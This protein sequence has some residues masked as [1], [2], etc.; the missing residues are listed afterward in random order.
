VGST[1][2]VY[3]LVY[4]DIFFNNNRANHVTEGVDI[5]FY[6]VL[7]IEDPYTFY[8]RSANVY[9]KVGYGAAVAGIPLPI[10]MDQ[11][12]VVYELPLNYGNTSSS[13][14]AYDIA[15]PNLAYYGYRQVRTNV[16]DGWG[17][18]NTPAGSFNALR[19]KTVIAGRD[20]IR[21]DTLSVAFAI[22]RPLYTEYKWLTPGRK[23]PVLQIN[24][25][26]ILNT[27]VITEV[28]FYDVERTLAVV[29]PLSAT[30][31]PGAQVQVPYTR[32][33]VFNAGGLLVP[34]NVFRVQLSDASGSFANPV[35]IGSVT[36]TQSGTITATIPAN[37]P[38]GT[39]YRVRVISTSPAFT[40]TDNGFN[41]TIGTTPQAVAS[42][43]GPVTFCAGGSV[44]LSAA[45]NAAYGYQWLLNGA[46][47]SGATNA[48]YQAVATGN[49]RVV[50]STTCGSAT[51]S[52]LAVQVNALPEHA[53]V[54][55]AD[56]ST[57]A[58]EP[59]VFSAT[60]LTGQTGLTYQ[61][62]IDGQPVIDGT[63]LE[64][65][66]STA[67]TY[68]LQVVNPSTGCGYTTSAAILEVETVPVPATLASGPTTVCDGEEVVL[69]ASEIPG[70]TYQWALDGTSIPGA[71]AN[72][73]QASTSGSYTVEATSSTGCVSESSVAIVVTIDP[74][75][76]VPVL[77]ANSATTFCSG[78]EVTLVAAGDP[79]TTWEWT[80]DGTSIPAASAS[81]YVASASGAYTAVSTNGFGCSA[82]A[83]PTVV[84][85]D[86]VPDQP[87]T[88]ANGPTTVCDG[89]SVL[90]ET[91]DAGTS[92]VQWYLD[93]NPLI[94]A[95]A[96][97]LAADQSGVYT[98]II[99]NG[100]G[101]ASTPSSA[102]EVIIDPVP[103][104]PIIS[105]S[106]TTTFCDGDN[107]VLSA[108]SDVGVSWQ[109]TLDG[110]T[111]QG[112]D[113]DELTATV[114]GT[115]AVVATNSFGCSAAVED[116]V[117][118]LVNPTPPVP[119]VVAADAVIFCDGGAVTL[120]ASGGSGATYQWLLDGLPIAGAN[121]NQYQAG[122]AGDY[123][124]ITV[125][126]DNCAS[127]SSQTILV[128]VNDLPETPV[129]SALGAT[130]FCDGG[131]VVLTATGQ[132]GL[133]YLWYRDGINILGAG[134]AGYDAEVSGAYTVTGIDGNGCT[135]LPSEP[136]VV[137][138]EPLPSTPVLTALDPTSF[139][140]GGAVVLVATA[141]AGTTYQWSV[142][143]TPI[144]GADAAQLITSNSGSYTVVSSSP[145]GCASFASLPVEV[146][147]F[148]L[149]AEPA[150]T[151]DGLTT[152]CAGESVT[153]VATGDAGVGYQWDLDGQPLAGATSNELIVD[154]TGGYAVTTTDANGCSSISGIA[155]VFVE[156]LPDAALV[157][158]NGSATLCE[159]NTVVL[160]ADAATGLS[161]QWL[162]D[163][164][165]ITG[166]EA[167]TYEAG[168]A[169]SYSVL[170]T[171]A[172]GCESV[173]SN[174]V[175]VV[176]NA[177]P[178]TP[179]ITLTEPPTFCEGASTT[180]VALADPGLGLQWTFN[181]EAID[182]ATASQQTVSTA[183]VYSLVVTDANGC[184]ASAAADV[185]IVVN[186][187]PAAPTV[188]Q[189][190][191]TLF[192]SGSGPFQW[193][194]NGVLIPN[195]VD[196]YLI[197][198]SNGDYTV[199]TTNAEGCSALSEV[200]IV[201]N[202]GIG[203]VSSQV[204]KVYPNPSTGSFT[205][206]LDGMP[207]GNAYYAVHDATGRLMH[208]GGLVQV[209]TQVELA[210]V[211]AGVYLLQVVQG[212]RTMIQRIVVER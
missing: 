1:N 34:N 112:A 75:P 20:S 42:A 115:Y 18:I 134:G 36:S 33:G 130:S 132:P 101:C 9:R 70:V 196:D 118:V 182:G 149:P 66:T 12:D 38:P 121:L 13:S 187:L 137:V 185:V 119:S 116:E 64:L 163:G 128:T 95:E 141:D 63:S 129:A 100:F 52:A 78:G 201:S 199:T 49:Y 162:L 94:G 188:T 44:T 99:T 154:A 159:G 148:T 51:S 171:S 73:Y 32:T 195:A 194:L 15:I 76:T 21:L 131:F 89:L 50:V 45:T 4:A 61:W 190:V 40:G 41:I 43:T 14:S 178:A 79:G 191:D 140:Q 102:V 108:S 145:T 150:L 26:R 183:G 96:A 170:V 156:V 67:G 39:G 53:L 160:E 47:L 135:S 113:E 142:D 57:C 93:G 83:I 165:T 90:L 60:N 189:N 157:T 106:G 211:P 210:G 204:F 87:V 3:S 114:S 62:L 193:Y 23:V 86:P 88:Q 37:T 80:L 46:A 7:P 184:T 59:A 117:T 152:F 169:G 2:I 124:A 186:S 138:V 146:T 54:T 192:A 180:M 71:D 168:A 77:S 123:T 81:E 55:P 133:A 65:S 179:L 107:V 8:Y 82:T 181:G 35:N 91:V 69:Q 25:N 122:V 125:S 175:A 197:V 10:T 97:T 126:A 205:I 209:L 110:N 139:C 92:T 109:W 105:T 30:L 74:L 203:D 174:V 200:V 198:E 120:I 58:D 31:C 151:A 72:V 28:F 173:A 136:V 212:E 5:P 85:V 172:L 202:V 29:P 167:A 143:G 19:V 155:T 207:I 127:A 84:T 104:L 166:A 11:Q 158:T 144:A 206:A 56:L 153:L 22:E 161:Y 98:V 48:T 176:V 164:A 27:E 68:T 177:L 103:V 111:I 24:T 147:V 208:Q 17:T 6:D 16:V